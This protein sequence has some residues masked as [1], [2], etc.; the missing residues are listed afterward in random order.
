M[1]TN[2]IALLIFIAIFII[3]TPVFIAVG[4]EGSFKKNYLEAFSEIFLMTVVFFV[5]IALVEFVFWAVG[6]LFGAG[7]IA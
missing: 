2:L 4:L 3:V 1:T 5:L 7:A 6:V